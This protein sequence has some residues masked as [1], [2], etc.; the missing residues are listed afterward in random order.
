MTSIRYGAY[1]LVLSFC[2][3]VC[4]ADNPNVYPN[5][6]DSNVATDTATPTPSPDQLDSLVA[7]IALYPDSLM[8]QILVAS[9]YPLEIVQAE[10]WLSMHSDLQGE[11]LTSAAEQENWDA[12]VQA[13]VVFPDVVKRL[14]QD[15]TWTTNLG[16]AF[17]AHQSDVMDAIQRMRLKAEQAGKLTST[18]QQK[19]TTVNDGGQQAIE[20]EP[21]NPQ[22]VYVPYYDPAVIWGPPVYYGYPVW[23]YPAP[24]RVGVSFWFGHGIVLSSGFVGCC[25]WGGWGWHPHWHEHTV[26]VNNH[27][28]QRYNFATAAHASSGGSAVWHHDPTHRLG[29]A[30]P[31]HTLAAHYRSGIA[32]QARPNPAQVR[33]SIPAS[34]ARVQA[35]P[36]VVDR[37]GSRRIS[38][39]GYNRNLSAFGGSEQGAVARIHSDRGHSSLGRARAAGHAPVAGRARAAGRV[40]AGHA[41]GHAAGRGDGHSGGGGGHAEH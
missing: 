40:N 34:A 12:S 38:P 26:I 41:V 31:S 28:I 29:V 17:L 13:L 5:V 24:P 33:A 11:A 16:N 35:H 9:T 1:V 10:Q 18:E 22:V 23:D 7:P 8:S 3:G 21:T 32:P 2:A 15:I 36:V 14:S 20:I 37:I 19:V 30:Y 6:A 39:T 27:F 25:G 4:R